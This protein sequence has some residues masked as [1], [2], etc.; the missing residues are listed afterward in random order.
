[1]HTYV[2]AVELAVAKGEMV[3]LNKRLEAL[4]VALNTSK[5]EIDSLKGKL[6]S[7]TKEQAYVFVVYLL[8][9]L[10]CFCCVFA[11]CVLCFCCVTMFD[12]RGDHGCHSC[13]SAYTYMHTHTHIFFTHTAGLRKKCLTRRKRG[14]RTE[15]SGVSMSNT[16]NSR[17]S[18]CKHP[19]QTSWLK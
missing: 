15:K 7:E 2:Q 6:E 12:A 10:L 18:C 19:L 4:Q 3:A 5:S 11:V 9:F 1:M 14:R 13:K 16:F 8:C 17:E